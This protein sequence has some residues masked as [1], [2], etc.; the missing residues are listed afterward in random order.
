MAGDFVRRVWFMFPIIEIGVGICLFV[1]RIRIVGLAGAVTMHSL[2]F[3]KIGPFGQNI[4]SVIWPWNLAMIA[5]VI[6][7]FL[8]NSE[9]TIGV[10]WQSTLGKFVCVLVGIFPA[11]NFFGF[12]DDNLSASLYSG[13]SAEGYV[14]LTETGSKSVPRKFEPFMTRQSD[15]IGF[16][17]YAWSMRE[18]NV[19][20]YPQV[21][22]YQSIARSQVAQ[23]I[24]EEDINLVLTDRPALT[25]TKTNP[26]ISPIR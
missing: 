2:L 6:I 19:P 24:P 21:R 12:W 8:K 9:S 15:R 25:E 3:L 13:R 5:L 18:L 1:P 26:R 16:D 22:V 17:I 10:A 7:T 11:L 14:F 4:N 23:G 20:P